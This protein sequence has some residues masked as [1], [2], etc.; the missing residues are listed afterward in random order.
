MMRLADFPTRSGIGRR[1]VELVSVEAKC[2]GTSFSRR[3][4]A[5]CGVFR[6][7]RCPR[8][9][10]RAFVLDAITDR[11]WSRWTGDL[12]HRRAEARE[13]RGRDEQREVIS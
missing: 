12:A 11:D 13:R 10:R 7:A 8:C 3:R 9:A 4:T 1:F 2:C 6:N 5:F